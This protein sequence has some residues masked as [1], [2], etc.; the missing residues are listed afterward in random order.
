MEIKAVFNQL[1]EKKTFSSDNE[2]L[3]FFDSLHPVS[4]GDILSRWKGGDFDN[5][6]WG[7]HATKEMKWFGKWFRSAL[8]VSPLVCYN[9]KGEL[10]SSKAMKGEATL[11][12]IDFRGKVSA[13][14]VYDGMPVFD[15]LRKVDDNTLFGIMNGKSCDDF[16]G[17]TDNK[18]HY[19]F[20]LERIQ[21]FPVTFAET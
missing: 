8:D 21:K 15:H 1:K 7:Y 11:W 19:F 13:A 17:V 5:G 10:Y 14:M 16:P 2:L 3:H 12:D 9:E 4:A 20:Y 6:H 18:R